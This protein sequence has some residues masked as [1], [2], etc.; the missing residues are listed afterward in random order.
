MRFLFIAILVIVFSFMNNQSC[1]SQSKVVVIG[2]GGKEVIYQ[3]HVKFRCI[4]GNE[5]GE[6]KTDVTNAE[7]TIINPFADN[8]S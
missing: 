3:A 7:G 2:K 8:T 4:S 6:I 1:Y 5:N